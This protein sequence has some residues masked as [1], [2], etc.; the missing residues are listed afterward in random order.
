MFFVYLMLERASPVSRIKQ[1]ALRETAAPPLTK[2][3]KSPVLFISHSLIH[4]SDFML[5]PV[6]ANQPR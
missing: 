5:E 3:S 1:E 4:D 6:P 2:I